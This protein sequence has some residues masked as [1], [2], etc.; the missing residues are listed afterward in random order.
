M[1]QSGDWTGRGAL[2]RDP[3][4]QLLDDAIEVLDVE[5]ARRDKDC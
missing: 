1:R 3:L 2:T 5:R 4:K